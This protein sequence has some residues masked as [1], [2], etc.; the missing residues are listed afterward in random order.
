MR[1][2]SIA[3]AFVVAVAGVVPSASAV[4]VEDTAHYVKR[5]YHQNTAWPWPYVCPDRI[6]VRQPFCQMIENGWRRQNLLGTH[7]F[8]P[9]TNELT[10]S[11][12][13]RVR[14][15][16][17]Q[18][19]PNRRNIFVERALEKDIT[20]ARLATVREFATQVTVDGMTPQVADTFLISEG[21]PASVVDNTFVRFQESTPP[22]V[23]PA[24][25]V[26]ATGQ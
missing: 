3:A 26:S 21:R 13:L 25:T 14:W 7:H 6:A 9:D 4:W 12:E 24:A 2:L 23:L 16:L 10:S 22:P 15:I 5:G 19:P 8:N 18:A 17:T 20:E 1:R 11:G